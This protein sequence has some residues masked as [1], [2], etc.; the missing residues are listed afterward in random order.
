VTGTNPSKS[1]HASCTKCGRGAEAC[2][3][4]ERTTRDDWD[5]ICD[6]GLADFGNHLLDCRSRDEFHYVVPADYAT[7]ELKR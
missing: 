5:T 7:A 3:W 6:C 1:L 2:Q 4:C